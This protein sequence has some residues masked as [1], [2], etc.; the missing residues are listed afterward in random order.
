MENKLA[1]LEARIKI[2]EYFVLSTPER[3]EAYI[4]VI[5]HFQKN[6]TP[7]M[8]KYFQKHLEQLSLFPQVRDQQEKKD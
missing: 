2:L 8:E 1:Y 3:L 7:E 5:K 4:E 6:T